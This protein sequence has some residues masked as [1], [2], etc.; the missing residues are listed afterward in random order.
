MTDRAT[1]L[2][3]ALADRY[4]LERELGSGGM[5][6]VYQA[7][8]VR[9]D[10]KVA[11]KVVHPELAAVLGAER[12]LSEIKT[13]AAL[14]HSHI[15]PLF[16]SG[17]AE[18]QLFYVMPLVEGESL[19]DRLNRETQLPI[20]EAVRLSREVA[21]ALSYAH[22][23]GIVHRDIKPEN[24]LLQGGHAL[25]ADFGIALAVQ[26]AGGTRLTQTGL[27]LGTP[28]YMAPEQAMGEKTV[29]GRADVYALGAVTYEMLT[30]EA[31]FSG[32]TAQ[33]IVAKLLTAEPV[34]LSELRK[35]IPSGVE[36]AVLTALQKLPA[37]RFGTAA[38]FATALG[39][40]G[41]TARTAPRAQAQAVGSQ[42]LSVMTMALAAALVVSIGV[43][44]WGWLRQPPP[45]PTVV[46]VPLDIG[47]VR[48]TAGTFALSPDGSEL[49]I[50]ARDSGVPVR[51]FIRSLRDERITIVGGAEAP[52]GAP[53]FSPDGR[54]LAYLRCCSPVRLAK[55]LTAGGGLT[56]LVEIDGWR[57]GSW[58]TGDALV[59]SDRGGVFR[60]PSGGGSRIRIIADS[61]NDL[62]WTN[63]RLLPGGKTII[64]SK[65]KGATE[66]EIV[67]I[68]L[69]GRRV[70]PLGIRS[71]GAFYVDAGYL[72]Y[73]DGSTLRAIRF[74]PDRIRTAGESQVLAEDVTSVLGD[75]YFTVARNGTIAYAT[76][77]LPP[78]ELVLVDRTG[79]A[80]TLGVPPGVHVQPR[81]SPDGGRLAFGSGGGGAFQADVWVYDFASR[82][83]TRLTTDTVSSR[84]EWTADGRSLLLVRAPLRQFYRIPADGSAEATPFFA[85][86]Q[87]GLVEGRLLAGNR[88]VF[89][90][91]VAGNGVRDILV[92]P[93]DSPTAARA[94]A[95]TASNERGIAVTT[96]GDWLAF[97]SDRS[98]TD[99]VY[100]RRIADGSAQ[101]KV[102]TSGGTEP[103]WGPGGRELF[104]RANDSLYAV[105]M[106][107][108]SEP[109]IGQPKALFEDRYNR[110]GH[111]PNYDVSPDGKQFVFPRAI[112]TNALRLHLL[113][114]WF[115]QPELK[116]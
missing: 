88:F 5:A 9:H 60:M 3:T 1:P 72:V 109:R 43:A 49:A 14:Q 116:R 32:P 47:S 30:G 13:T 4:T 10:R 31:P 41:T 63:P 113:L 7:H 52:M 71:S 28:Q 23:R 115:A 96:D 50:V 11:I 105:P 67:A 78:S 99:E 42:R 95:V 103:R 33:A 65:R 20:E 110:L 56:T 106:M 89:R 97:V 46:R 58:D 64:V 6:T 24:I 91:D 22:A 87:G 57:G 61:S 112:G 93:V 35:T 15:L 81:F 85:R 70:T 45:P 77:S 59:Y 98:G 16:D 111:E 62:R 18:G 73:G 8:D 69:D 101:W 108:A 38:E 25:V 102:S 75:T 34:R 55:V 79:R 68:S 2:A 27:S 21:D 66:R 90:E 94:L 83:T 53:F 114:N 39:S 12:F 76:G 44:L 36:D 92:A 104:Y 26:S 74:D 100:I 37:D 107:L 19:R 86:P 54:S 48:L 40:S 51:V 84:P 29:D 82:R 17:Q 80:E